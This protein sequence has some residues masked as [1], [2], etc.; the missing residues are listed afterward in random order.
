VA[1]AVS[2]GCGVAPQAV[3]APSRRNTSARRSIPRRSLCRDKRQEE[4][5]ALFIHLFGDLPSEQHFAISNPKEK[6][7]PGNITKKFLSCCHDVTTIAPSTDGE[8]ASAGHE[9]R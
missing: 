5:K 6:P 2:G 3:V 9:V 4:V 7:F 8:L 1:R